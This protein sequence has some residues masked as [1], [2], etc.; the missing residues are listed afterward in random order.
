MIALF[1]ILGLIGMLALSWW[2]L[3]WAVAV[4]AALLPTYLLRFELLTI[5]TTFLEMSI[6]IASIVWLYKLLIKKIRWPSLPKFWYW[7]VAL[8]TLIGLFSAYISPDNQAG[9][10][11][12]KAYFFDPAIFFIVFIT[13]ITT[14]RQ[15]RQLLWLVGASALVVSLVALWQGLGMIASPEPWISQVPPRVSS[16][17]EYPN[18]LGLFLAPIIALFLPFALHRITRESVRKYRLAWGVMLFGAL[19]VWL[20]VSQGA[21][22]GLLAAFIVI[23]LFSHQRKWLF[24]LL[25]VF[26]LAVMV[27]PASRQNIIDLATFKDTSGDVRLRL[28][29]GTIDMLKDHLIVGAG[30]AGFPELYDIYRDAAHV[31]LSL[32]PHNIFLNFWA[33]MGLAGLIGFIVIVTRYFIDLGRK[34][35]KDND[36]TSYF[37]KMGLIAA[38]VAIIFHGLVDVPYFKNDLAVLFWLLIGLRVVIKRIKTESGSDQ[39]VK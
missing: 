37:L 14:G 27:I 24:I 17:F 30:L 35:T 22:L 39:A 21:W 13:T 28:W 25:G 11:L 4:V 36:P 3:P 8:W 5:P 26:L 9:L 31:E 7:A 29:Q 23:A 34:I 15:V 32:Y 12:W 1:I 2:R 20:A 6:Y 19:A 18:A 16:V 33:T 38:M 10:G